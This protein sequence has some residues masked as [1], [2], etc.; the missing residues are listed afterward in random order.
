MKTIDYSDQR[1]QKKRG[2]RFFFLILFDP[3]KIFC[4]LPVHVKT[5]IVIHFALEFK[6]ILK[7][8]NTNLTTNLFTISAMQSVTHHHKWKNMA[9]SQTCFFKGRNEAIHMWLVAFLMFATEI[10]LWAITFFFSFEMTKRRR[11]IWQ[12]ER[13]KRIIL[14]YNFDLL[15]M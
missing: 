12:V 13:Q 8:L 10:L 4:F 14:F 9:L 1:E 11:A 3:R 2:G 5:F 7:C 6:G 15:T